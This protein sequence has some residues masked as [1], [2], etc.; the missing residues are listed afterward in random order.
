VK[1]E[2]ESASGKVCIIKELGF[3]KQLTTQGIGSSDVQS[4]D[5]PVGAKYPPLTEL[6]ILKARAL[7]GRAF[8]GSVLI[9]Q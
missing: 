4:A 5:G 8:P 9:R 6:E 2:R 3:I 7:G 1:C